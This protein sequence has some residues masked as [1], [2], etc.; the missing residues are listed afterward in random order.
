MIDYIGFEISDLVVVR[1]VRISSVRFYFFEF[2]THFFSY[3][4]CQ[5]DF[6]DGRNEG[7]AQ[8]MALL[9]WE[10]RDSQQGHNITIGIGDV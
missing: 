3:C 10:Q 1:M 8:N 2:Q 6:E 7:K 4:I 5:D 9:P